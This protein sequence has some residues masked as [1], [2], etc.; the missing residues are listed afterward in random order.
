ML[1]QLQISNYDLCSNIKTS[2]LA[3]QTRAMAAELHVDEADLAE[4]MFED[5]LDLGDAMLDDLL[6]DMHPPIAGIA[7][8]SPADVSDAM[9]DELA[10]A[11]SRDPPE[12][13][14]PRRARRRRHDRPRGVVAVAVAEHAAEA[15]VPPAVVH[16][17]YRHG[18]P[19]GKRAAARASA[20]LYAPVPTRGA[21]TV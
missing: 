13:Q 17:G 12:P 8:A 20:S 19:G 18:T 10:D 14:I 2:Y 3:L 5:C 21:V 15:T 1:P 16:G 11:L 7:D 6:F 9:M 4:A